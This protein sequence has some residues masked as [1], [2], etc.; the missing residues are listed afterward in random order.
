MEIE[1][2]KILYDYSVHGKIIDRD[3]IGKIVYLVAKERNL[4][5]HIK[6][7]NFIGQ[8]FDYKTPASYNFANKNL[9][10]FIDAFKLYSFTYFSPKFDNY[11]EILFYK[12]SQ[13][14]RIILHE[15]EHAYESK[16]MAENDNFYARI[17]EIT[18]YLL[19]MYPEIYDATLGF[20]P[21]ER[22]ANIYAQ[23]TVKKVT[24]YA[25]KIFPMCYSFEEYT[26][27]YLLSLGY[28]KNKI[29]EINCPLDIYI[30]KHNLPSVFGKKPYC[31]NGSKKN[32]KYIIDNYDLSSRLVIGLPISNEEYD[33]LSLKMVKKI[34]RI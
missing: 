24:S 32:L 13:L 21:S 11:K 28:S 2:L 19:Q 18:N 7:I 30:R 34:K 26:L 27:L 5:E 33:N 9:N 1:I 10:I 3:A 29:N 16:Y 31:T 4:F 12:N 14:I 8:T 22:A 15:L 17:L 25:K 6:K 20:N 23:N